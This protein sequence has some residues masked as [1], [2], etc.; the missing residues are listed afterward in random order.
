LVNTIGGNEDQKPSLYQQAA[1]YFKEEPANKQ[2]L[3][4][5]KT[6]IQ[7]VISAKKGQAGKNCFAVRRASGVAKKAV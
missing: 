1:N 3:Q 7:Q 4:L 6:E 2:K 5:I